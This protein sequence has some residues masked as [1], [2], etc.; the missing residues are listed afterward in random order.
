MAREMNMCQP[1]VMKNH[2]ADTAGQRE[3]LMIGM[4]GWNESIE[5]ISATTNITDV[6]RERNII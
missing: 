4:F 2:I 1:W 3:T 6:P 5:V